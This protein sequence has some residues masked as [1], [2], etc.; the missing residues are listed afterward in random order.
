[1]EEIVKQMI[2]DSLEKRLKGMD[3][4][5][6]IYSNDAL[7]KRWLTDIM[8]LGFNNCDVNI[9]ALDIFDIQS[10]YDQMLS[11]EDLR[12]RVSLTLNRFGEEAA[13]FMK[14]SEMHGI[15]D[16]DALLA[17]I[18]DDLDLVEEGEFFL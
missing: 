7:V 18:Q 15:I 12:A 13:A 10:E 2:I 17:S 9:A 16:D 14:Y 8:A 4:I 6:N 5:D 3:N 1:M 11:I